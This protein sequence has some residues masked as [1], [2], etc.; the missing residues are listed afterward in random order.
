MPVGIARS[1]SSV[2]VAD[3]STRTSSAIESAAVTFTAAEEAIER[4]STVYSPP[5][6]R[7]KDD[8]PDR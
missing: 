4:L 1:V 7:E 8:A 2:S 5:D 6:A 3:E